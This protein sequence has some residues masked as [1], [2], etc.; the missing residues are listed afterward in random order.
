MMSAADTEAI[1][2]ELRRL[3]GAALAIP[4]ALPPKEGFDRIRPIRAGIS[5][6]LDAL[7]EAA[8]RG[9]APPIDRISAILRGFEINARAEGRSDLL[10]VLAPL[11]LLPFV[12]AEVDALRYVVLAAEKRGACDCSVIAAL[13]ISRRPSSDRLEKI[14]EVDEPFEKYEEFACGHCGARF[15]WMDCSTEQ[16]TSFCWVLSEP[17]RRKEKAQ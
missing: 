6:C 7:A 17:P 5:R 10:G 15:K 12:E 8:S 9:E 11:G 3:L 4:K 13:N 16:Y 1:L 2:D 14:A